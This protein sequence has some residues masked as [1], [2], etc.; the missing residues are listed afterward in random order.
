MD[1]R[2]KRNRDKYNPYYLDR[3]KKREIYKISIESDTQKISIY[4]TEDVYM[5]MDKLERKEAT[6]IQWDKRYLEKS[7][8]TENTLYKRAINTPKS[9]EEEAINKIYCE[10]LANAMKKLSPMH[11]RRILLYFE[12]NLSLSE[13]AE[14]EGC[15]KMAIKYSIDIALDKLRE[16]MNV[17]PK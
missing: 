14:V 2:P 6:L 17:E 13:I 5:C 15:S 1:E 10:K 9:A 3:D 4:T 12:H 8:L 11:R 16:Y 7:N